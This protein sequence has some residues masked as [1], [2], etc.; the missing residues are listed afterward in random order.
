MS[1]WRHDIELESYG[2]DGSLE[3]HRFSVL[4]FQERAD[5]K[6]T[7][8]E[9]AFSYEEDCVEDWDWSDSE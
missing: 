9:M 4:S 6:V 8:T 5:V 2:A 3:V 1:L 7:S